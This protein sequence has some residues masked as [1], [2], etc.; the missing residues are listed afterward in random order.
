MLRLGWFSTGRGEGSRGFL[1]LIQGEVQAGTLDAR[2]E[3]VFSSREHG[4]A[5]GSDCFFRLVEGYGLPLITLSSQRYRREHGGGP[6]SRHRDA[7]HR[8]VMRLIS[9]YQPDICVLA[10]YMLITSVEMCHRYTMLNLHPAL[11]SGPPGTWQEV[12]WKL[13]EQKASQS[14]VMV[15]VATEVLDA[16]PVV[17]YCSFPIRG[18]AFDPLWR[19]IESR[20]LESLRAEGEGQPLFKQIRLEGMRRERPLL[21]ET[22]K[23]LAQRRLRVCGTEVFDE[24]GGLVSGV[25]LNDEVDAFL[26]T[27]PALESGAD[28]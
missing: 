14:G 22:L 18:G 23:A 3:F 9:G 28:R 4:E 26:S 11:P 13:V 5:E 15:H 2:I 21:L 19:E 6:I 17:T 1:R 10:G 7:Y 24:R 25:C 8:E 27:R 16:G 12:I 20:S